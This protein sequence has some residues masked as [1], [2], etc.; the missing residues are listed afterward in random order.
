MVMDGLIVKQPYA[1][2]IIEGRKKWEMR[3]RPPPAGKVGRR[4]YLLSDG[5]VLGVIKIVDCVGPLTSRELSRYRSLH[6]AGRTRYRYAWVV[7]VVR[8]FSRPRRYRHPHG[9]RVWVK[10][11]KLYPVGRRSK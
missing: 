5:F 7:E 6:L 2:W 11:V 8:R 4:V 3:S 10:N 9:A 1:R